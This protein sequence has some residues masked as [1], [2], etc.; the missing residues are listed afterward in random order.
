MRIKDLAMVLDTFA[1]AFVVLSIIG[2]TE[3]GIEWQERFLLNDVEDI[4]NR[5]ISFIKTSDDNFK[6]VIY[7][8]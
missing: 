4:Y 3:N 7:L 8:K 1:D 6:M 5:E 2:D